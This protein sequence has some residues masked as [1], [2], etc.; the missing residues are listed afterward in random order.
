MLVSNIVEPMTVRDT[1]EVVLDRADLV[2]LVRKHVA[3]VL[4]PRGIDIDNPANIAV[5]FVGDGGEWQVRIEAHA[6]HTSEEY[7]VRI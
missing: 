2:R 4:R 6:T 1:V 5:G 3:E 7:S